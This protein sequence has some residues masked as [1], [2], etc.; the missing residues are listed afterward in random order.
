LVYEVKIL[1]EASNQNGFS[2]KVISKCPI[3]MIQL[4]K[5]HIELGLMVKIALFAIGL[6]LNLQHLHERR[7]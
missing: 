5:T 2:V 4:L 1:H 6:N 7:N 3:I